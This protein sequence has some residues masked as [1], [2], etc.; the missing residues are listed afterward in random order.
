[1]LVK[2]FFLIFSIIF[3]FNSL[4]YAGWP[5]DG[6]EGVSS[7]RV[8]HRGT[9]IN[10]DELHRLLA[11][12]EEKVARFLPPNNTTNIVLASISFLGGE[13]PSLHTYH[14]QTPEVKWLVFES[15]WTSSFVSPVHE[16]AQKLM[17]PYGPK[18][19]KEDGLT[20]PEKDQLVR[21]CIKVAQSQQYFEDN[22]K[23]YFH[24]F[25]QDEALVEEILERVYRAFSQ[26]SPKE[27]GYSIYEELLKNRAAFKRVLSA[28]QAGQLE[29][30]K[31]ISDLS[32]KIDL[33]V[34]VNLD[35]I[36][37]LANIVKTFQEQISRREKELSN[38]GSKVIATYWHSEQKFLKFI[39]GA[40]ESI[41]DNSLKD[42]PFK[43]EAIF[44][45]IHSRHD[46]CSV[47]SHTLVRS[48]T[49]PEG[50]FTLLRNA[51]CEKLKVE[52]QD[53]PLYVTSSFREKREKTVYNVRV[54]QPDSMEEVYPAFPT[55]HI[56]I[57]L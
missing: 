43:P 47:C 27:P 44:I 41:L 53:L 30:G 39:E 17:R 57:S 21:D 42:L 6:W 25:D 9:A 14:L 28:L 38:I 31:S 26:V 45:N 8:V 46:I 7:L 49:Q 50:T 4:V 20:L 52:L 1:M 56:P 51:F 15:G 22:I 19:Q 40:I 34:G 36:K 23:P 5:E 37:E 29:A 10:F 55:V 13:V 11:T 33:S 32:A 24:F 18:L 35:F 2:K 3:L 16:E 12:E 48:Y 54:E